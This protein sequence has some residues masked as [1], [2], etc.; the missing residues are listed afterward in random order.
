[1]FDVLEECG[2]M[3]REVPASANSTRLVPMKEDARKFSVQQLQGVGP[4]T[5]DTIF[6]GVDKQGGHRYVNQLCDEVEGKAPQRPG[7]TSYL[8]DNGQPRSL[9]AGMPAGPVLRLRKNAKVI[10]TK[11]IDGDIRNGA[12]GIV[13]G[14]KT[15][16]SPMQSLDPRQREYHV[17][18]LQQRQDWP[19]VSANQK[20]PIVRFTIQGKAVIK[21]V[22]PMELAIQDNHGKVICSRVQLPLILSYALTVHRA[23]GMTLDAVVFDLNGLFAVGQLYTALSRVRDFSKL[24]LVGKLHERLLCAHPKVVA[25]EKDTPWRYIDNGPSDAII[26]IE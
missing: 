25:F 20:W 3:L 24:Y 15:A 7:F 19:D 6:F 13:K 18:E 14:F 17:D 16:G 1:M 9:Y 12:V 8:D 5:E 23:Q 2:F 26:T 11:S 22:T 21:V 10:C 4:D